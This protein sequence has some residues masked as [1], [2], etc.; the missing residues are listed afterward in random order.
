MGPLSL[1]GHP[2]RCLNEATTEATI[3]SFGGKTATSAAFIYLHWLL[4]LRLAFQVLRTQ[5]IG[6]DILLTSPATTRLARYKRRLAH[7]VNHV[8]AANLPS[9][10]FFGGFFKEFVSKFASHF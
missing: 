4:G 10:K 6:K 8:A 9:H 7:I 5:A 1:P 3:L 2:A